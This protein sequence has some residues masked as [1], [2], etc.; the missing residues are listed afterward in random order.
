MKLPKLVLTDI[1]GVWT[2]GGMY[3]TE[4]GDEFKKFTT[5]DSAGVLFL[6]SMNIPVGIITGESTNIVH[7]RAEKL[8]IKY[9]YGGVKDKL[10]C[11][12]ELCDKIGIML[13]DVAYIG[14]DINDLELLRAVGYSAT[15]ISAP[16]YIKSKVNR[17]LS[18]RG[19]DGVFREFVEHIFVEAGFNIDDIINNLQLVRQ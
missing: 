3:Y 16:D 8:K 14:D 13:E 4:S 5:I 2:D 15:P 12:R 19:G 7:R 9:C 6:S 17:V 11:A 18:K 10:G 1:D